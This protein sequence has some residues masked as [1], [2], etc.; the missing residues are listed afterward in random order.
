VFGVLAFASLAFLPETLPQARRAVEPLSHTLRGYSVLIRDPA[1]LG[2][3]LSGGFFYA[4]VYAFL[5]GSP[6]AY[7][8]YY[9]V[10][11]QSYGLLFALNVLGIMAVNST[12]RQLLSRFGSER[13][14]RAGVRILGVSGVVLAIDSH[15]ELGGLVGLVIP[16]VVFM[17]MNGLIVANSVAGALSGFPERA[18]TASSL[19]GVMHYGAGI[20]SAALVG[21]LSNGTPSAM[22]WV[23]GVAGVGSFATAM[24]S[25]YRVRTNAAA[26]EASRVGCVAST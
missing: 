18:G 26:V 2:Y 9:G 23:M 15:F 25:R 3:G 14:F 17:S 7:I 11:P 1:L 13:L 8:E 21:W 6:Y 19:I 24:A 5:I 10:S 20:V 12:N 16:I 4:G 22:A